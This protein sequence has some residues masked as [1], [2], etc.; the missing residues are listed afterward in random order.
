MAYRWGG[1]GAHKGLKIMNYQTILAAAAA[2]AAVSFPALAEE[3]TDE[4]V[5]KRIG[6]E[7]NRICFPRNIN[8][9]KTVDGEDNVVLLEE[10]VNDWYR[11]EVSGACSERVFRFAHVIGLESR[12]A[13]GCLR[14]GDV[15]L[16]EDTSRFAR[17]CYIKR[18]YQWDDDA[19]APGEEED[20]ETDSEA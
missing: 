11:V 2:L 5:D 18:I 16:V 10:G 3:N 1:P 13:G 19:P 12:P 14:R 9:W 20:A 6:E 7:V 4:A 17:R 15:I 8:G